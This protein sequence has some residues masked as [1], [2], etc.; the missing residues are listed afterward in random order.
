MISRRTPHTYMQ[1]SIRYFALL[2]PVE[3]ETES[4]ES[5]EAYNFFVFDEEGYCFLQMI[6]TTLSFVFEL[7]DGILRTRTVLEVAD[8][9]WTN[10]PIVPSDAW[11][12]GHADRGYALEILREGLGLNLTY[13]KGV[14][15]NEK[16]GAK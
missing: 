8:K 15:S 11:V 2:C 9:R 16:D 10:R 5:V 3:T 4:G 12:D 1:N 7:G 13:L 14:L 6:H